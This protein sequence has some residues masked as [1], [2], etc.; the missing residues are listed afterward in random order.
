MTFAVCPI[1]HSALLEAYAGFL[2]HVESRVARLFRLGLSVAG[3][4]VYRCLTSL[5]MLRF[6]SPL[7]EPDEPV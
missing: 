6:H 5:A 7:I 3:S 4:F 2:V 1:W